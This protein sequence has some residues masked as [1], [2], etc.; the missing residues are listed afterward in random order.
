MV[1]LEIPCSSTTDPPSVSME[2][3]QE[4]LNENEQVRTFRLEPIA[5]IKLEIQLLC[6]TLENQTLL[7]FVHTLTFFP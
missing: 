6:S 5:E 2:A 1:S 3:S 7:R 4:R